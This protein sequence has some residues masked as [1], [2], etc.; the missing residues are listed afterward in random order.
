MV[1]TSMRAA[2][3]YM[4]LVSD[5]TVVTLTTII[6]ACIAPGQKFGVINGLHTT[7]L[8]P[9][10]VL[11]TAHHIVNHLVQFVGGKLLQRSF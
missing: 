7:M 8:E 6:T 4:E 3:G 1:Y 11:R 10:Q 9:F 5:R 2:V